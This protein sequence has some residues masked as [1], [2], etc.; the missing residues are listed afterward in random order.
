[1]FDTIKFGAFLAKL[2]KSAD[3]TQ[4]ELGDRLNLT[5]QAIS[6]YECGDSFPDI[7]ILTELSKIFGIPLELLIN[8][9]DPTKGEADIIDAV[10]KGRE[11]IP[12]KA[13]DVVSL[14]PL[15]KPSVITKLAESLGKQG[16]DMSSLLS[17]SEYISETDTEKLMKSVSFASIAEMALNLLER[18]L[19]VLGPYASDVIFQK[20][21]D[22]ELD[23]HYLELLGN[24][25]YSAVEAA[26]VFGVIDADSINILRR[27]SY[28]RNRMQR[29]GVIRLFTCPKCGEPL[30]HFYPRRCK[31]G[32]QPPIINN[33]LRLGTQKS[34]VSDLAPEKSDFDLISKRFGEP[35]LTLVLGASNTEDL[36]DFYYDSDQNSREFIV[37][38][39]DLERLEA[40]EQ[41]V[42]SKNYEQLLFALDC[43]TEPHLTSDS[44]DLIIDNTAGHIGDKLT[45]LLK[46]GG[47]IMRG[48]TITFEK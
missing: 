14:A 47:C 41:K 12:E 44:F 32:Y 22:G 34:T 31:C 5:R 4:S 27:N 15:L 26:V 35:L 29:R 18:L 45:G 10:A 40:T 17:L 6:R 33:I 23:Y 8:S 20:I 42:R 3:M 1:M 19:P 13:S 2:R 9:G 21:L 46:C 39:D 48:R 24:Y 7:S 11:V 36:I 28:N 43:L 25:S 37:L 30:N 16:I 38:D